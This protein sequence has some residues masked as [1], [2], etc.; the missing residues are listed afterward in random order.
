MF[1]DLVPVFLDTAYRMNC[2]AVL[3]VKYLKVYGLEF[4]YSFL[5]KNNS[6]NSKKCLVAM[7]GQITGK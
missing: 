3:G 2:K 7:M 4:D 5:W 1:G 6:G